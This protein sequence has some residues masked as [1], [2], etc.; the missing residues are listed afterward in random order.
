MNLPLTHCE[1]DGLLAQPLAMIQTKRNRTWATLSVNISPLNTEDP[2]SA[3]HLVSCVRAHLPSFPGIT[4]NYCVGLNTIIG[5]RREVSG[6]GEGRAFIHGSWRAII[7]WLSSI[8][9]K[10]ALHRPDF[11]GDALWPSAPET[12][13]AGLHSGKYILM[14]TRHAVRAYR[15]HIDRRCP[16][17]MVE[18]TIKRKLERLARIER[19]AWP[20]ERHLCV[21]RYI[22]AAQ[23]S[24]NEGGHCTISIQS[25][26]K[27]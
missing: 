22:F 6:E 13:V 9:P 12:V 2:E 4:L 25:C 23:I 24:D 3:A 15:R 14:F 19:T 18:P 26:W 16:I 8:R 20:N 11:S 7:L 1:R 5:A 27:K 17:K 21:G 10:V